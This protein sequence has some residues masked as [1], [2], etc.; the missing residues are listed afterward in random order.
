MPPTNATYKQ[1]S[2]CNLSP[3]SL[4]FIVFKTYLVTFVPPLPTLVA[5]MPPEIL[6]KKDQLCSLVLNQVWIVYMKHSKGAKLLHEKY[7][8]GGALINSS[9]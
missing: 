7:L 1:L 4:N 6:L 5:L 3:K 2:D 8:G 9:I